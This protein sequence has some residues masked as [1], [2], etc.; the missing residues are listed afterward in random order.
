[1]D[2]NCTRIAYKETGYFSTIITDYLSEADSLRPFYQHSVTAAGIESAIKNRAAFQVD[3]QSLVTHLQEQYSVVPASSI[4]QERISSLQSDKTFT[5]CT[6]H[7]PALF[8]GPLYFIYKILHAIKL[9]DQ[10]ST[11]HPEYRFVP[12][13]WMGNEDADLDELGKFYLGDEKIVWDTKQKGAVG[14]MNTKGLDKLIHRISGELTVLPFGKELIDLLTDA[15]LGSNDI[16][17]ATFKFIN[18]LFAEYGLVVLIPDSAGLKRQ[19]LSI[20]QD[21]LFNQQPSAIV[22]STIEKLG[23]NYK[24]QANPREIY[25]FYMKD[26]IRERIVQKGEDFFIY[27]STIQFSRQQLEQ[28]LVD[29][30][31]RFS[32]NVI[33]RGLY[34]EIILPNIAFIGGGGETAYWL[35]L[36]DLFNHFSVPFPMLILRNSFLLVEGKWNDKIANMDFT[37][38]DFFAS[39]QDLLTKLVSRQKNGQLKLASEIDHANQL[40]HTLKAKAVEIDR[41]LKEHVEALQARAL[42]PIAE[43]E[44]KMLRAEKRKYE[45]EQRQIHAVKENLFPHDGLQERIHSFMP[46]Y[47]KWGSGF[48]KLLYNNSLTLEQEFVVLSDL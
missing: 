6:A 9:A 19:M 23:E 45:A 12:V 48:L 28:E 34:Q 17:T 46:Y 21:D 15:Y 1:M 29:H 25:L 32:P 7:Q 38:N 37:I 36:K 27:N 13:Y 47:A 30:P 39:E 22:S 42:K 16:Q 2:C 8:T 41:S 43:L 14:R 31:E 3:R 26:D 18:S 40:Y 11:E 33:L 20:F 44:K 5:V 35:E 4:V 24:V 10:L